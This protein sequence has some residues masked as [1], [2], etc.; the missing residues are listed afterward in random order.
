[1][2]PEDPYR[3]FVGIDWGSAAH[4]VWVSAPDGTCIAERVVAHSGVALATLAEWLVTLAGGSPAAVA[5]CLEIPRGPIVDTLLE[6]GCHVFAINPKQLDRFRDRFSTAGAKDD[7]RDA[8]VLSSAVRTD[9]AALQRLQVDDPLTVEL[10]EHSRQDRELGEDLNRL[11]NRLREH[12]QRV[13]PELLTLSP[14]A[15]ETWFWA[16][17]DVAP[18]PAAAEGLRPARVRQLLRDH[19]IRRLT[20][21]DV[22]TVLRTP[23][24]QLAPGV[25]TGVAVRIADLLEQLRV[26][27]AQRQRSE[28]RLRTMLEVMGGPVPDTETIR[29]HSDVAIVLALPGIGTRI[30]STMLAE[31]AGPLRT[32]DY[33][34]LRMLTGIAPVTKQ[35]GKTRVV[36][37]RH[38]CDHRLQRAVYLWAQCALKQDAHSRVHYAEL[39]RR[40]HSNARA[41]RGV[42][43]RLLAVLCATLK[44]RK[45]Y[46]E[47]RRRAQPAA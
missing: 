42:A 16:L 21:E 13:W 11:V 3:V 40:G 44:T 29:E 1:M 37:M 45:L 31:A 20:A 38:A 32:R 10:R 28:R 46:D 35:S 8:R 19:R 5:V 22:L 41:L 2:T 4:Q 24:V 25:R 26:V 17:L 6:R 36:T 12:L 23:S 33:H 43:D 7:R 39:R 14:A 30:A 27:S 47:T 9:R 34:A 15:D 18:T